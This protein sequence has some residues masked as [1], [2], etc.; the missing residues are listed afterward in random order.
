MCSVLFTRANVASAAAGIV[1]FV[2]YIPYL[3]AIQLDPLWK[4]VGCIFTNSAMAFGFQLII[5]L[6]ASGE[7]LQWSN[8]W[9]PFND[10]DNQ[11]TVGIALCFIL[12]EALLYLLIA[13]SV[14]KAKPRY[15][16]IP[17]KSAD[18]ASDVS[19]GSINFED[20]SQFQRIGVQVKN[21]GKTFGKTV[22]CKNVSLNLYEGQI[23]VILGNNGMILIFFIS[24]KI[25]IRSWL[26]I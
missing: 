2:L 12:G 5:R 6:E 8:F 13:L 3:C 22:A 23:T 18:I 16:G 24:T 17:K 19:N 14:E 20:E 7:G 4:F 25:R 11:M 10:Y 9:R 1:W 26:L 15:F 21:L